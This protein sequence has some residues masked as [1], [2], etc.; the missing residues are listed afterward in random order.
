MPYGHDDS[1]F[2]EILLL[3]GVVIP[4]GDPVSF[5]ILRSQKYILSI[6]EKLIKKL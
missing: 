4:A 5:K 3:L 2:N 1:Q 6:F